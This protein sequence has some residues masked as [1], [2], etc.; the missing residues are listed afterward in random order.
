MYHKHQW[1]L[2][3]YVLLKQTVFAVCP[4]FQK[5]NWFMWNSWFL[6][7]FFFKG[8]WFNACKRS[9]PFDKNFMKICVHDVFVLE[10][11]WKCMKRSCGYRRKL[12][13]GRFFYHIGWGW[14]ILTP[15]PRLTVLECNAVW[16]PWAQ[17]D[18]TPVK[19]TE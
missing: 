18:V 13:L 17:F 12:C 5:L 10:I 11:T 8:K 16:W 14:Q 15:I 7:C 1:V 4:S 19:S 3:S 2:E 6:F 9:A